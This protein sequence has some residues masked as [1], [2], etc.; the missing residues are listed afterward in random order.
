MKGYALEQLLCVNVCK[1]KNV[2]IEFSRS[3]AE[4]VLLL[5]IVSGW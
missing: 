1:K 4:Y 3:Y 2:L 5:G